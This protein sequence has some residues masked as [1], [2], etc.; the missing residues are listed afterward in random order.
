GVGCQQ[1]FTRVQHLLDEVAP[2]I[3]NHHLGHG[4]GL[5]P[6]E[7]PHLNPRWN[8]HFEVGDFFTVEPG[9]YHD[10]LRHGIRLEQNYLVTETGVELLTDFDL[11]L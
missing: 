10:D 6:Q 9:L 3:F 5:A 7:G 11:S 2:W 1:L 4:V 8:D